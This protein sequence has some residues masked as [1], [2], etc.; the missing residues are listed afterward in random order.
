MGR[1]PIDD[2]E[3]GEQIGAVAAVEE[4]S[5]GA[6]LVL[7]DPHRGG[8]PLVR[9]PRGRRRRRRGRAARP[10]RRDQR[11]PAQ[12]AVVTNVGRDHTDGGAGLA[13]GDRLGEG[14]AS[15]SPRATSCS[16][17]PT[18]TSRRCS[19]P[20]G[21]RRRGRA[22][23]TSAA[24]P[25]GWRSVGGCVDLWTPSGRVEDVYLP[26]HGAH[27]GD[28]AALALA[29]GRGLLRRVRPTRTS[30]PRPSPASSSRGGSRSCGASR[31]SCSTAPTTSTGPRAAAQHP[32]RGLHP[33]R[34]RSSWSS[35]C[36]QG[37]DP[38]EMLEALGATEA[39]FVVACTPPSPRA[40]PASEVAAAAERLGIAAEAV[41][42]VSSAVEPGAGDRHR[43][44]P[45]ARHRVAT[46]WWATLAVACW[47]RKT[48]ID[49]TPT[50]DAQGQRPLLVRE[51]QEV[52][53]LPQGR[54]GPHPARA[55]VSPVARCPTT[56]DAPA[57]RRDRR[58]EPARRVDGEGRR[59]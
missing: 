52:Q 47:P 20:R 54:D 15:S 58:P 49:D 11:G 1:R 53:A 9:R 26:V 24:R 36:S 39:G 42:D 7:R 41:G 14:R 50:T 43:R 57:L 46:T 16:A 44:R 30:S 18:R 27:Q 34:A 56:I 28:N 23:S 31:P 13:G 2:D 5:R 59:R 3:L 55:R 35:A 22:T 40:I 38:A 25:T 19:P 12:V 6:A 17:R 45:G 33:G 21:P 37:R 51:R 29:V 32:G 4:L 10:V 8:L 48:W